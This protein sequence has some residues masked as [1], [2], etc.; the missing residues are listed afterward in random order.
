MA[1]ACLRFSAFLL[2]ILLLV[3]APELYT[4][5]SPPYSISVPQRILLRISL[6]TQ[7]AGAYNTFSRALTIY[8]KEHPSVHIRV[9]RVN[10]SDLFSFSDPSPD[11]LV[12]P[13]DTSYDSSLFI[14][15]ES[16]DSPLVPLSPPGCRP[17]LCGAL[18]TAENPQPVLD[19]LSHLASQALP[20]T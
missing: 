3:Y 8:M 19:L 5:I 2:L 12:F 11:L 20:Q 7:D 10:E 15:P 16:F 17:L 1:K 14:L 18:I 9:N 13:A 4:A 6:H